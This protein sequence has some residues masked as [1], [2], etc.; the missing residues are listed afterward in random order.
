MDLVIFKAFLSKARYMVNSQLS[1]KMHLR[2]TEHMSM[3]SMI[4][5]SFFNNTKER[6]MHPEP[7][8][9]LVWWCSSLNII[10]T[11]KTQNQI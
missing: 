10:N 2:C 9:R 4:I 7:N 1:I 6:K 5:I 3:L 8:G 11:R